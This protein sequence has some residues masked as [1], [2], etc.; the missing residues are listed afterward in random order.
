MAICPVYSQ[1]PV[2]LAQRLNETTSGLDAFLRCSPS[3]KMVYMTLRG[4]LFTWNYLEPI[5]P[6]KNRYQVSNKM[7][8]MSQA[9]KS[10]MTVALRTGEVFTGIVDW[11]TPFD[12]ALILSNEGKVKIFRHGVYDVKID[13]PPV[14]DEE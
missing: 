2:E 7:L 14:K 13:A 6:R 1:I 11:F 4:T 3:T 5:I 10:S 8:K 12:I 9:S